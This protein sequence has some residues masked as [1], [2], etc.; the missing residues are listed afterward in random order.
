MNDLTLD[1]IA[2]VEK[3]NKAVAARGGPMFKALV[4]NAYNDHLI[5][6]VGIA[7]LERAHR[8]FRKLRPEYY[9]AEGYIKS[10]EPD[11]YNCIEVPIARIATGLMWRKV[12]RDP[13]MQ[14]SGLDEYRTP[15]QAQMRM[16]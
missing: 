3:Q 15:A 4:Q 16:F 5:T 6:S 11:V 9:D 1:L 12:E 8:L 13:E 14:L 2:K 7:L 10:Y